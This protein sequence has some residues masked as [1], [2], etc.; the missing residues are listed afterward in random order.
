MKGGSFY[1]PPSPIPGPFV[2]KAWTPSVAGWPGVDGVSGNRNYLANNLY[3]A[4]DPQTMMKLGGSKKNKRKHHR[5][6]N[7]RIKG[8]GLFPQDLINLGRDAS[9]NFKSAYNALG[10]YTAPV[11]PSPYKDQ[12][13]GSISANRIIV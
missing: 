5:K 12:L 8:G 7:P 2:G 1:K 11:N 3:N 10:G 4:G 9:F 13:S 6:T